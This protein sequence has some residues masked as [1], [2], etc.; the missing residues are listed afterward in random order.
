MKSTFQNL[1]NLL[2][3]EDEISQLI[4]KADKHEIM[5]AI[6]RSYRNGYE[7]G[8]I[9]GYSEGRN[10]LSEEVETEEELAFGF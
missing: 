9:A 7:D 4:K 10:D 3:G 6:E 1:K 8:K 5:E 2:D